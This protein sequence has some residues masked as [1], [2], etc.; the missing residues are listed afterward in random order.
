MDGRRLRA[1]AAMWLLPTE[2]TERVFCMLLVDRT[3]E[4]AGGPRLASD[5]LLPLP[6]VCRAFAESFRSRVLW[7]YV[8]QRC[9][10]LPPESTVAAM[11]QTSEFARQACARAASST[12]LTWGDWA[13]RGGS[14]KGGAVQIVHGGPLAMLRS[15]PSSF[16]GRMADGCISII[17]VDMLGKG[18]YRAAS[19][20]VAIPQ[21]RIVQIAQTTSTCVLVD[22]HGSAYTSPLKAW[23]REWCTET[24][25]DPCTLMERMPLADTFVAEVACGDDHTLALNAA[26]GQCFGWGNNSAGQLGNVDTTHWPEPCRITVPMDCGVPVGLAAGH[27]FSVIRTSVVRACSFW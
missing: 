14:E 26:T 7:E 15:S 5:R 20:A 1:A 8:L 18:E 11:R 22:E 23:S 2:L 16:V 3:N 10:F 13:S 4:A 19:V 12:C 21:G 6:L 9:F 27:Q 24:Q 25:A 17:D